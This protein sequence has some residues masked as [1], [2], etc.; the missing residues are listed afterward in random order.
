MNE[1]VGRSEGERALQFDWFGNFGRDGIRTRYRPRSRIYSAFF[2][3][4]PWFDMLILSVAFSFFSLLMSSTPGVT[5]DLPVFAV[6]DG[7]R[8]TIMIVAKASPLGVESLAE[9]GGVDDGAT[10]R[11]MGITVFLN[12][13]R[14]NLS[15]PHHISTFRNSLETLILQSGETEALLYI[16]KDITHE[17]TMRLAMLLKSAGVSRVCYVVKEP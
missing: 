1:P 15:Q 9:S 2:V 12:D 7:M 8:S 17:N 5:V 4:V 16:D 3:V 10:V 11:P 13:S 6:K 14:F